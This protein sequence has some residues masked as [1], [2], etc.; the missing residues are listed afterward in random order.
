M[1]LKRQDNLSEMKEYLI[2]LER[3]IQLNGL[4]QHQDSCI[5]L[6]Y[7]FRDMLNLTYEWQ[8]QNANVLFEKNHESFDLSDESFGIACQVTVTPTAAKIR[9]TLKSFIGTHHT[10]YKRLVFVYPLIK[11]TDC[12]S[13]FGNLLNGYDFNSVRDRLG[14][15]SV[16]TTAQNM[17]IQRQENLLDLIR[18]ELAPLGRALQLG[19]DQTFETLIKVINHM[20][21]NSPVDKIDLDE[22]CPD[23]QRK[24]RRFAD[25]AIYLVTQYR[26]NQGLHTTINEAK[27]AIGYDSAR[28]AKIQAWLK[29]FSIDAL[30][31]NLNDAKAA[32]QE[33]AAYLLKCAHSR[34]TDA[35]ET[36][37]RFMLADEL[38][39][40]N[41]FPNL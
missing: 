40:C 22:Q 23:V 2:R 41:V 39:R 6:E 12:R 11:I 31:K 14:L 3:D 5:E 27:E 32:F 19:V 18:R 38:V 34:G 28:V 26:L 24:L 4:L 20:S 36:A 8:L 10:A 37:V 21:T 30:E 35:E 1:S 13:D 15:G 9:K 17:C 25:H 16:L 29:T 7:F 33:M